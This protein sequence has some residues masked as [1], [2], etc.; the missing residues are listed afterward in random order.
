MALATLR[1]LDCFRGKTLAKKIPELRRYRVFDDILLLISESEEA[2]EHLHTYMKGLAV[3]E[4]SLAEATLRLAV[5]N[6]PHNHLILCSPEVG[7]VDRQPSRAMAYISFRRFLRILTFREKYSYY[8]LHAC[9]VADETDRAILL[10][11]PCGCGKTSLTAGL[12]QRG[13][14]FAGDDQ[15]YL[16][17][18]GSVV[19]FPVGSSVSDRAFLTFPELQPLRFPNCRF[20]GPDG[21]EWTVNYGEAFKSVPAHVP[22]QISQ[23]YFINAA[24]GTKSSVH[25]CEPDDAMWHFLNSRHADRRLI[26]PLQ[27][28][29]PEIH[30]LHLSMMQ[31][32]RQQAEFFQVFN[33]DEQATADLIS[34]AATT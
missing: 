2:A 3:P 30:S 28:T 27:N 21:W 5:F 17:E 20:R 34:H 24:F 1:S 29:Y 31:R 14:R 6:A 16:C 26:S 11:G 32:L 13:F 8:P 10:C 25:R 15:A 12:L 9:C 4:D 7:F 23:F 33:G 19:S 18:N 22:L